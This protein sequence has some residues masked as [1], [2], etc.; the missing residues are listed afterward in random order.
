MLEYDSYNYIFQTSTGI[1]W[2]KEIPE[3]ASRIVPIYVTPSPVQ[4]DRDQA[5][6]NLMARVKLSSQIALQNTPGSDVNMTMVGQLVKRHVRE[7]PADQLPAG[8][9]LQPP[10]QQHPPQQQAALHALP[11]QN[12]FHAVNPV[13]A[14]IMPVVPPLVADNVYGLPLSPRSIQKRKLND[15]FD[16]LTKRRKQLHESGVI[17]G[18]ALALIDHNTMVC[19]QALEEVEVS[20][21]NTQN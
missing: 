5:I 16:Q 12:M 1:A 17:D 8:W 21:A 7:Y 11:L 15:R 20:P 9:Q 13:V 14:P 18:P 6:D 2:F 19:L 3:L 4:A 10:Q